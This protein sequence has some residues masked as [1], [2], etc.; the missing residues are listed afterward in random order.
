LEHQNVG[1]DGDIAEHLECEEINQQFG[2]DIIVFKEFL[3]LSAIV[4]AHPR[5][6]SDE[7]QVAAFS[8]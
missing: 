7:C 4:S 2:I 8:E 1:A 5:V 3:K 6:C